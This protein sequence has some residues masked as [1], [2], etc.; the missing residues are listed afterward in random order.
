MFW[1][2]VVGGLKVLTYWQTYVAILEYLLLYVVPMGIV[3]YI[4]TQNQRFGTLIGCLTMPI[5]AILQSAA[6]FVF[7][8]TLSPIL[9]GI[10]DEA[11]WAFPFDLMV[12]SPWGFIKVSLLLLG[13]AMITAFM[14]IVGRL[15]ALQTTVVGVIGLMLM[16]AILENAMAGS[17]TIKSISFWPGFWFMVGLIMISGICGLI[18][19]LVAGMIIT[20]FD[21]ASR[22]FAQ[23]LM[24][25]IAGALGF[26][27][28]FMYAAWLGIQL[29]QS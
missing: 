15:Q 4:A 22:G 17:G 1:D 13:A 16:F 21:E 10:A 24:F 20:I 9:L 19:A 29:R 18:G 25:P 7:I 26:L 14:P 8:L 28:M 27:P 12:A 5:V 2:S 11:A 6:T 3:G 23:L